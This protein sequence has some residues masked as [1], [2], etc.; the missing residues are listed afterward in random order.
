MSPKK[1]MFHHNRYL[2]WFFL[3]FYGDLNTTRFDWF[4]KPFSGY[5]NRFSMNSIKHSFSKHSFS[6]DERSPLAILTGTSAHVAIFLA[7]RWKGLTYVF[8]FFKRDC[9]CSS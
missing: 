5:V 9:I 1:P 6:F 4:I 3:L 2:S 8:R 7:A